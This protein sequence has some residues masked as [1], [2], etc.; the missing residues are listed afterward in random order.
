MTLAGALAVLSEGSLDTPGF[1]IHRMNGV[2]STT[3]MIY[4]SSF[5]RSQLPLT[6]FTDFFSANGLTRLVLIDE[7]SPWSVDSP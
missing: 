1:G 4:H 2:G 7:L 5:A 3:S 6:A